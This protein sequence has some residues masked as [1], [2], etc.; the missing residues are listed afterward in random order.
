MR[1]NIVS[2]LMKI[3]YAMAVVMANVAVN[4]TCHGRYYQEELNPQLD[5]LRK[6]HDK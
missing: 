2:K 1:K 6:Y 5:S 3:L 4:T